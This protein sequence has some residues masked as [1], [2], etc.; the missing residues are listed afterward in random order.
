MKK[1]LAPLFLLL[2]LTA[3]SARA[4]PADP[5]PL[6]TQMFSQRWGWFHGEAW[7]RALMDDF[8]EYTFRRN[9]EV[10]PGYHHLLFSTTATTRAGLA[11]SVSF[12][13]VDGV[14]PSQN[15]FFLSEDPQA[16]AWIT[17][18]FEPVSADEWVDRPHWAR[19]YRRREG[20]SVRYEVNYEKFGRE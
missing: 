5:L 17:A 20:G 1:S 19:I 2:L 10:F 16:A 8:P 12:W 4:Q 6:A 11:R 7:V 14:V 13:V 3:L 15:Y 18:K 9:Q